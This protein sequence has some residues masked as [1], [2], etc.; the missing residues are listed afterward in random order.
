MAAGDSVSV[1]AAAPPAIR[2]ADLLGDVTPELLHRLVGDER[3]P[4]GW[5]RAAA[6]SLERL[7]LA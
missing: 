4:A 2:I 7:G 3:V 6:R 1:V 5:R